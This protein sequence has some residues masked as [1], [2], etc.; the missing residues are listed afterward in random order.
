MEL[1]ILVAIAAG[2]F[3]VIGLSEPLAARLRL[4]F[5]VILAAMG[6]GIGITATFFW[7]TSLTNALNPLAHGI[8]NL[9]IRASFFLNV[10][11]PLLVFQVA[12]NIDIRRMLDDWVPIIVLAVLAVFVAML[13][14]GFA[15]YPV[16]GLPLAACLLVGAIVSTTDPSA[17][18]SIF[19]ATPSPQRLARIVEGESL[20]NDAAAIALFSLFL[21]FVTVNVANPKIGPA[22]VTFP[23]I[24]GVGGLIG[25][26]AGRFAVEVI[27]R[28]PD[29]PRGQ[30]SASVAVP[31]LT[32]LLAEQFSA[33]GVIAVVAAGLTINL[34]MTAR[35]TP[36][37]NLQMRDTW[38]LIAHWAGSLI[39]ILA[40]ILIP[41]LLSE[42]VLYDLFLIAIVVV[43]A[44]VARALILFGVLPVLAVL[45]LSP[46][47][48]RPYSVA[49]LWGGLRGAVTLALAL[50]VTEN[51]YVPQ[52]IKHQVGLIATGF[53][54]FTLIVQGTTLRWI[55]HKLK[56]DRLSP[57][58]VALSN[59]VI[60]VALQS[61]RERVSETARDL[62]LTREIVRDEA[63]RFAER[64]DAAV[65]ETDAT[66][67]LQDRDR[68]TLGLVALAAHERD[69]ILDGYRDQIISADL[70][71]RL[72]I[73]A[74]MIIEATRTSGR[75]GYRAAS[76]RVY[77]TN[78]RF[79]V[80]TLLHNYLG[81]AR[82]LASLL[83]DRF[84]VL[85]SYSMVLPR[86]EL[87]IDERIRRIHGRRV[88]ELLHELL[89]RR[90][91]EAR[92]ELETLRLQFPGYAEELER[93]L[94]R[95]TT[96]QLEEGEYEALVE[97]GLIGPEL[98]ATLGADID[99][100]R[101]QLKGRPVLDLKQQK[102]VAVEGFAAFSD[103]N[104]R[105]RKLLRKK[106]RI[107]YAAP[108]QH[109]LRKESSAREVWFIAAGTVNVV[110]D[111][112]KLRLTEG[113]LF[114]QFAVLAKRRR[115]IQVTAVTDCTLL[116][117]DE[118]TVRTFMAR[119]GAFRRAVIQSAAERGVIIPPET[120]DRPADEQTAEIRAILVKSGSLKPRPR[121]RFYQSG[122]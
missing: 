43:A 120:F 96:L 1:A 53:T 35:F 46:K 16:A 4:P 69:S 54:L 117:L 59:Q 55:I 12:L 18:V 6:I 116:T 47:M 15:L 56:L 42:F 76:R 74:D 41:K 51:R 13:A 75:A 27:A 31:L 45:R 39:F 5:S 37:A 83:E 79:R 61:V 20:L 57:L 70:A 72:V 32:Y 10:F 109:I 19:K 17:V 99:K 8:L 108:G 34:H 104:E 106:I 65:E 49:I 81:I 30:I 3:A 78:L 64:V 44:L 40:A 36:A 101:A 105:E 68:I 119:E 84:D 85:V 100:R 98:R 66:E 110:T 62:G 111:G 73:G 63:K 87:F 25:I 58:D 77:A 89:N 9:P 2:I 23:W 29:F 107:V 28:M 114:G 121:R 97:D 88:A 33:S 48:E 86:L 94:I 52:D 24:A 103:F 115:P 60:A 112:V 95:R 90:L 26:A 92:R 71:E 22:L 50:A 82:P 102:R 11:L 118:H 113:E 7:Q 80:A 14:V 91:E 21:G 38:D 93:R 122:F 67:Q